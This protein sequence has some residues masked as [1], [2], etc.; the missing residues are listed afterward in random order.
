MTW[1]ALVFCV[2][3]VQVLAQLNHVPNY[4]H[5]EDVIALE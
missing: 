2:F 1:N 5:C 3:L 4:M